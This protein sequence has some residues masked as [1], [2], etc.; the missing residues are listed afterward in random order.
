MALPSADPSE[1]TELAYP[2]PL[3]DGL[4]GCSR[5]RLLPHNAGCQRRAR[6]SNPQPLTGH[7]Y[8][9]QAAH[10]FAYPP[11]HIHIV[12][13]L[14]RAPNRSYFTPRSAE[15]R[16]G[17]PLPGRSNRRRRNVR[18]EE[19]QLERCSRLFDHQRLRDTTVS[20][21]RRQ[22]LEQRQI[23]R[24]PCYHL[25]RVRLEREAAAYFP[26]AR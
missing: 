9:K 19:A 26:F 22:R 15:R 24:A 8:S 13:V 5:P 10:Q 7:L 4:P 14:H 25:A 18:I 11:N 1:R 3:E 6:D 17:V 2:N 16:E 23:I 21:P 20:P 12:I